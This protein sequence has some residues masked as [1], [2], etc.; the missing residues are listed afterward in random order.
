MFQFDHILSIRLGHF[1]IDNISTFIY[2]RNVLPS[3]FQNTLILTLLGGACECKGNTEG[4]TCDQCKV[5]SYNFGGSDSFGCLSCDCSVEGTVN[6]DL[7]CDVVS[8]QCTCKPRV[9]GR[10]CDM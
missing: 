3:S 5:N 7:S 9:E 2:K 6:G 10:L 4:R 1:N 8:G